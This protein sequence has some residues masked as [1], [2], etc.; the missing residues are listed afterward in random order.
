M[1]GI[2]ATT[3]ELNYCD[4]V[5]SAIQTQ[6]TNKQ[7]LAPD[8]T[9]L[10]SCQTGG[11][12]ALAALTSTEIQIL[13]G[14]SV[15]T[16]ELNILGGITAT[17]TELNYCDGVTS[18]IQTQLTNKQALAPDLTSLSICQ[19]GGAAALAA[20]TSTEIQ[21]L[22]GASVTTTELNILGGITATATELN[23]CDG[24]TSAIQTQLTNKPSISS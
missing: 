21:I 5:T 16:T 19:T 24:V 14:A 20:L 22:D 11:A 13:D 9:S 3:T 12:A 1:G 15:T 6:L 7:A 18:A 23:Y 2:T 17:A 4:G 10:S 8:L